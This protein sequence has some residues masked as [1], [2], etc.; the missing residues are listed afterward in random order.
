MDSDTTATEQDERK[1]FIESAN[2]FRETLHVQANRL[3]HEYPLA[4]G[5]L[6][7]LERDVYEAV[8]H[9][10]L[11]A[12]PEPTEVAPPAPVKSA[13]KSRGCRHKFDA[14][15]VCTKCSEARKRQRK[16]ASKGGDAVA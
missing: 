11:S 10:V 1:Q 6:Y 4:A 14:N 7:V 16:S 13:K 15:G 5:M 8:S 12:W 3:R 2:N 9:R